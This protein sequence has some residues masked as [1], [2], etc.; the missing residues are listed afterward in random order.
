MVSRA[1][2]KARKAA[3]AEAGKTAY[4]LKGSE[5]FPFGSVMRTRLEQ[6][7]QKRG[8]IKV[9]NIASYDGKGINIS[10]LI[11]CLHILT[12]PTH[13]ENRW[14]CLVE[15]VK[16]DDDIYLRLVPSIPLEVKAKWEAT[17]KPP[18]QMVS[19]DVGFILEAL[20]KALPSKPATKTPPARKARKAP[21][22]P[23]AKKPEPTIEET[24]EQ[25]KKAARLKNLAIAMEIYKAR[26]GR[27]E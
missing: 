11:S 27:R 14:S 25:K 22:K 8:L 26:K 5:A 3:E 15:M 23:S 2:L 6:I 13:K 7:E 21:R 4:V 20:S 12:D 1:R 17:G 9:N 19:N 16:Y 18:R 24:P 10:S